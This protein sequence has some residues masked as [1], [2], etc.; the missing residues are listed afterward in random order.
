MKKW[1]Q[2]VAVQRKAVAGKEEKRHV[3]MRD[4]CVSVSERERKSERLKKHD[5][6]FT[7][8]HAHRASRMRVAIVWF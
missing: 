2:P 7:Q 3:C 5:D 6:S 4:G 1:R 8:N